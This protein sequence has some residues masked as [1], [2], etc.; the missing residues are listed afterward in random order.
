MLN[1]NDVATR[2]PREEPT[3]SGSEDVG[4]TASGNLVATQEGR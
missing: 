4:L 1:F 2:L 3:K